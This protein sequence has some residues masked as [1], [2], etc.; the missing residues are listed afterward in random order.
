MG[1][2]DQYAGSW[3]NSEASHLLRR[4]GFGGAASDRSSIAA[5]A[6]DTAVAQLVDIGATDTYLDQA[7]TAGTGDY[8]SPFADLID[9]P[10]D[11]MNPTAVEQDQI[12]IKES[13]FGRGLAGNW[14]YRMRFSSEPFREQYTLFLHD[15][16][17]CDF[18][19]ISSTIPFVITYGNDG[20][21]GGVLQPGQ[22]Q[23]CDI[24][25][26]GVPPDQFRVHKYNTQALEDQLSL[27]RTTG[28]TKFNDLL[29]G[30]ARDAAMLIY[31]DNYLNVAGRPQENMARELM[32]LFSLGVGNYSENDIQQIAKC[33]TG[34]SFPF[35]ACANNWDPTPGFISG[36]HEPGDKTVFGQN[37]SFDGTGQE[38]VDVINLIMAKQS[39]APDVSSLAPPYNVPPYT[40]LPATAVYMSWKLVE[41]FSND[42]VSLDPP[43]P[44]VLELAAYM[45]GD[46][47]GTYPN[48]RYPYDMK[49]CIGKLLRSEYF[50]DTNNRYNKIKHPADFLIGSLNS[51]STYDIFGYFT[52]LSDSMDSLGME[53]FQPP[54]VA[55]WNHGVSWLSASAMLARFNYGYRLAHFLHGDS[56]FGPNLDAMPFTYDDHAGMIAHLGDLFFHE[57]LTGDEIT[58]LMNFL[59]GVPVA[60]I[61]ANT[62]QQ[63]RRKIRGLIHLMMSM[64]KYQLK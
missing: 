37:V 36:L 53:L 40:T 34:E 26:A 7:G 55:G 27:F 21:P 56:I 49:A 42:N 63:K 9:V 24:G 30:I 6:V 16:M 5:M 17:P 28:L 43:D 38:T 2:F 10:V 25:M 31:L 46:D 20:D 14:L 41:W 15:H 23:Q 48:R 13:I 47:A 61:P 62:V 19:K 45:V 64:P 59:A 44:I 29:L 18:Q 52:G 57:T 32:E 60:D 50:Y 4:A 54:N 12:L 51:L 58:E 33:V 35:F 3:T 22:V 11:P 1:V 39:V 8:G